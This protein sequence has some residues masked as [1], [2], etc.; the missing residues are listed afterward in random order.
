MKSPSGGTIPEGVSS[1]GVRVVRG[2]GAVCT[3]A[4]GRCSKLLQSA[5]QVSLAA[6]AGP[7]ATLEAKLPQVLLEV[8]VVHRPVGLRFTL[9]LRGRERD[10]F[11]TTVTKPEI[12][13]S[14][15]FTQLGR[16]AHPRAAI[17]SNGRAMIMIRLAQQK[18]P[19][20]FG[21]QQFK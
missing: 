6:L 8:L 4:V 3:E 2:G 11:K 17:D 18:Q 20:S 10:E 16:T 1:L 5:V 19:C 9:R 7:R 14:R 12:K 15:V 13:R 21:Q